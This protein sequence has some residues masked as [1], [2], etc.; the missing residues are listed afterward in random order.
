MKE[1]TFSVSHF[2]DVPEPAAVRKRS[3]LSAVQGNVLR[4]RASFVEVMDL[5][6]R[7]LSAFVS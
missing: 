7:T 4:L 3:V 1:N 6:K 5:V 2:P